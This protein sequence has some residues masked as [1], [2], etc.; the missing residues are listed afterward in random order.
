MMGSGHYDDVYVRTA[1][2]WKFLSRKL[3]MRFFSPLHEGWAEA[4]PREPEKDES[5]H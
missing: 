3:N 2:G 5:N 1:V 4:A